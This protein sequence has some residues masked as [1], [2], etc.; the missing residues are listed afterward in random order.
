M[1]ILEGYGVGVN[2]LR[3][4]KFFWDNAELVCRASGRYGEIF[5]AGR[6]VTQ[7][8]PLSPKIFNIMVDA[9]VREWLREM[10]LEEAM[11]ENKVGSVVTVFLALFYADDGMIASTDADLLQEAMDSLAELFERVGLFTN[12]DKTKAMPM[13]NTKVRNPT[14][15]VIVQAQVLGDAHSLRSGMLVVYKCDYCDARTCLLTLSAPISSPN[16][17]YINQG[18]FYVN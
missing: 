14:F 13:V 16:M 18:T 7:G 3:L 10:E 15:G 6:G 5:R 9:I 4:I 12:V 17:A 1:E 2:T 8:G 11:P